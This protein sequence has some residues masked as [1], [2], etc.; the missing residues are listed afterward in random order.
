MYDIM[1]LE[2]RSMTFTYFSV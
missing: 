1:V 2:G